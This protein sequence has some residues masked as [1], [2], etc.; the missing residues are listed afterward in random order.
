[1]N[2]HNKIYIT[3][4]SYPNLLQYPKHLKYPNKVSKASQVSLILIEVCP[5][6]ERRRPVVG[7]YLAVGGVALAELATLVDGGDAL[8]HPD[9]VV[10]LKVAGNVLR[11]AEAVGEDGLGDVGQEEEEEQCQ[12]EVAWCK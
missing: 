4:A 6:R 11:G 3:A 10:V 5:E 1:M 2:G 8:R 9:E 7:E 12:E